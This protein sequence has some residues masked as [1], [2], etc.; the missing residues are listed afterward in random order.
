MVCDSWLLFEN[1]LADM[2]ER[3][4]GQTLDRR[5]NNKGYCKDNCRWATHKEQHRNKCSNRYL[6]FN[7]ENLTI[8]DWATRLQL[9]RNSINER[10]KRGWTLDR[11]LSQ[12]KITYGKVA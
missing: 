3:P 1:F 11:A 7:G 6:L 12:P 9:S 2:G 5:D 10:L 4:D 8:G